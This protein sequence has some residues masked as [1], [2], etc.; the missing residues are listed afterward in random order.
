[1]NNLKVTSNSLESECIETF[2]ETV[3]L[4]F[5]IKMFKTFIDLSV[6]FGKSDDVFI[7]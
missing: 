1:M 4:C 7:R 5:H 2:K 6:R 3:V